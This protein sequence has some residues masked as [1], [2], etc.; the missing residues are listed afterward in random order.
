MNDSASWIP[1]AAS[2]EA[3]LPVTTSKPSG[4]VGLRALTTSSWDVPGSASTHSE[5]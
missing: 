3:C 5:V 4:T 2:S 1:E